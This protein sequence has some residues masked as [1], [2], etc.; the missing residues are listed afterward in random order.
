MTKLNVNITGSFTNDE[1]YV[2]PINIGVNCL[3]KNDIAQVST[4]EGDFEFSTKN[5]D[6]IDKNICLIF[7]SNKK[8]LRQIRPNSNSNTILLTEQCDQAC[9]MCS[10][11]PKDKVYYFYDLYKEAILLAPKNITIGI[12]GGE[13]TLD[14]KN[15]FSFVKD[16]CL[17]RPDVKFHILTNAQHFHENDIPDLKTLSA[18]ILWGIPLYSH[19]PT[20][21]DEIVGKTGAYEKL[22][23]NLNILFR[24]GVQIELRT[25]VMQ[26]NYSSLHALA[27]FI[28]KH[29]S[30]CSIWAIM[31]LENIGYARMNWEHIFIDTSLDFASLN[32]ALSIARIGKINAALY[33][34]PTCTVPVEWRML[35]CKSISDWKQ[36]YLVEC[37]SC[38]QASQ[39][40]GFFSW[41]DPQK[42]F[43]GISQ[44]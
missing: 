43:K 19:L 39:C 32:N 3:V 41:Y 36:T 38:T 30:M 9:V 44:L 34:F 40:C 33:N 15:L 37:E 12:S 10:Q 5:L 14:K 1:P 29:L 18:N 17:E 28:V 4:K 20:I 42:G 24:A 2:I 11:P 16:V 27:D 26:Q 21:H 25:V 35:C 7:P 22:L 23:N 13:P 6:E 8:L 31:Q